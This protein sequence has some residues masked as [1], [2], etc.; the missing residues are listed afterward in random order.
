MQTQIAKENRIFFIGNPWP[1]GHPIAEFEWSSEIRNKELFFDFHL[2]TVPYYSERDIE[3]D[4]V[5]EDAPTWK[6]PAAWEN[7]HRCTLSSTY[8][9]H[10][11]GAFICTAEPSITQDS[12]ADL[13]E[14]RELVIDAPPPEDSEDN[15]F[16][17][18]LLGHDSAAHHKL[19]FT[20]SP[21]NP[22]LVNIVWTGKIALSYSGDYDYEH[23]FIAYLYDVKLPKIAVKTECK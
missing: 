22:K 5:D 8:W 1:E 10:G 4:N 2:K 16:N 15:F 12:F 7:F 20:M 3:E 23:D 14:N 6:Q 21:N 11:D 13:M 17:I 18:Y 9:G 19:V